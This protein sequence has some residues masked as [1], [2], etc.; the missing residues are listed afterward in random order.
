MNNQAVFGNGLGCR[1]LFMTQPKAAYSMLQY[2]TMLQ[3]AYSWTSLS[4]TEPT[5]S[6]RAPLLSHSGL[7]GGYTMSRYCIYQ[8]KSRFKQHATVW[9]WNMKTR[10]KWGK[11]AGTGQKHYQSYEE[12][13][14]SRIFGC[15]WRVQ[16]IH[17]VE[18]GLHQLNSLPV[19]NRCLEMLES[20]VEVQHGSR[21]ND[22]V[23]IDLFPK[24]RKDEIR[25]N[26]A[27]ERGRC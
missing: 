19:C 18:W 7:E 25:T 14:G 17:E 15:S 4:I 20:M 12:Y 22:K 23:V 6:C 5:L 8:S 3:R 1:L 11:S 2:S 9:I 26:E 10:G 27:L 13:A 16:V 24:K 21:S